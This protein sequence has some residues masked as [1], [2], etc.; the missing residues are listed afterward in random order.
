MI[1]YPGG[2]FNDMLRVIDKC[3]QHAVQYNRYMIID[4]TRISWF[5]HN[6]HTYIKFKHPNIYTGNTATI[7]TKIINRSVYPRELQGKLRELSVKYVTNIGYQAYDTISLKT[8]LSINYAEDVLVYS[9]YG[10]GHA[11]SII[12][13]YI[14]FRPNIVAVYND[15]LRQLSNNY[16][17]VHIRNTDRRSCVSAFIEENKKLLKDSPIFLASD[18]AA[19]IELFKGLFPQTMSFSKIPKHA[20]SRNIHCHHSGYDQTEFIIDCIVDILLLA[21]AS[22]YIYS[23]KDSGY[24]KL[25]NYLFNDKLLLQKIVKLDDMATVV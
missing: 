4:S 13:P 25:A 14:R 12:L 18:H 16:T 23:C 5:R 2:G 10:D 17:S 21:S 6:I 9:D 24:S 11:S 1:V 15:R 8:N 3:L 19:T 20:D 7:Y 22:T